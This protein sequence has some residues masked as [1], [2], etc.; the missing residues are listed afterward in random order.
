V[1]PLL[2]PALRDPGADTTVLALVA[3]G[4]LSATGFGTP[5]GGS[6]ASQQPV[7]FSV[8]FAPAAFVLARRP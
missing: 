4:V 6:A 8:V 5:A 3:L 1:V 2:I 7:S